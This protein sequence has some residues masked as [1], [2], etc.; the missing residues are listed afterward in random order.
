M[1]IQLGDD[2]TLDT[3]VFCTECGEEFRGTW[4]DGDDSFLAEFGLDRVEWLIA[5]VTAE[6]ECPKAVN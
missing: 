6:H 3:V 4:D 5:D 1:A 2:G